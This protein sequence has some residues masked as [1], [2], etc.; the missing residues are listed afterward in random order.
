MTF[1]SRKS[2]TKSDK[3][4]NLRF[5]HTQLIAAIGAIVALFGPTA[6]LNFVMSEFSRSNPE[7]PLAVNPETPSRMFSAVVRWNYLILR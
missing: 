1:S 7:E 2:I 6:I 3:N 5:S 4:Q